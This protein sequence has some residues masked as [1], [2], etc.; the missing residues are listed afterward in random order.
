MEPAA[1]PEVS[2]ADAGCWP[3]IL[4]GSAAQ[5]GDRARGQ[6]GRRLVARSDR[7]E[8]H[9]GGIVPSYLLSRYFQPPPSFIPGTL[10][11]ANLLAQGTANSPAVGSG[12]FAGKC[13]R[14]PGSAENQLQ[15]IDVRP[16]RH[17]TFT[18]TLIKTKT[19]R[20]KS[21]SISTPASCNPDGSYVWKSNRPE[22]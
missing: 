16:K 17:G 22:H 14:N 21:S 9:S 19:P 1:Q 11:S 6:L 12:H 3:K 8:R 10:Y 13:R 15:R 4:S 2:L 7:H 20:A 18:R 5:S